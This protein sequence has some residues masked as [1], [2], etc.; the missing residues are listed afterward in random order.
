MDYSFP[1]VLKEHLCRYPLMSAQDCAKLAF[2]AELGPEHIIADAGETA[3]RILAELGELDGASSPSQPERIS[4]RLCRYPL[5]A[6]SSAREAGILSKLMCLSARRCSGSAAKLAADAEE[7]ERL[8]LP[9]AHEWLEK[10]R[11]SGFPAIHHS[12]AYREAYKPHYRLLC[13]EYSGIIGCLAAIEALCEKQAR[14]CVA[15]EG[16]CGAGKTL[17]AE[18]CAELFD[19]NVVHI[20]DF[21]LPPGQRRPDWQSVPGGNMDFERFNREVARSIESGSE[22]AFRP[23]VCPRGDYGERVSLPIKPLT[24]VEGSYCRHPEVDLSY[25]LRIYFTCSPETQLDRLREREG[26]YL[27]AFQALWIPAEERYNALCGIEETSD[28][29][30]NTDC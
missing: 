8:M 16:R 23:Y 1:A 7:I 26:A 4:D 14:V 15:V 3:L 19:C 20:D 29:I 11:A 6:L 9:D 24:I 22:I 5:S 27:P 10:W 2:Q 30:I 21:Y 25:D 28:Y 12:A 17:F 13:V 18:T